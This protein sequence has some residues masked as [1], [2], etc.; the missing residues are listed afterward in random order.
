M[1]ER[2]RFVRNE[3]AGWL[4]DHDGDLSDAIGIPVEDFFPEGRDGQG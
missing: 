1:D 4:R 3:V 2:G